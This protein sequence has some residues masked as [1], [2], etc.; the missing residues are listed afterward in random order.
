MT[1]KDRGAWRVWH[2]KVGGGLC[3]PVGALFDQSRSHRHLTGGLNSE[4]YR[5]KLHL[6]L[7]SYH[8]LTNFTAH[9]HS[10]SRDRIV[11]RRTR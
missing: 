8:A 6:I 2:Q 7:Y 5:A 4:E 10:G 11:Q 9:Q 1:Q 3:N